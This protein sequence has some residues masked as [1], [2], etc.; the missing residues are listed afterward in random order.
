MQQD[1]EITNTS[2]AVEQLTVSMKQVSNNAEASA[3]AARRALDA[4]EQ[5]N[6]SVRDTLEGMQRIRSSVQATAKRIKTLGDRSLEI[7]E[8][9]KVINDI[10][11]QTNLLA[12][13]PP[14]KLRVPV[15]PGADLPWLLTK[16]VSWQNTHVAL[17]K[18]LPL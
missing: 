1:Q 17:P 15:K 4:A 7:S 13:M 5:G 11:E 9:V 8:I 10:T 16:S 3:E 18:T 2:S 6:R 12:S 14:L